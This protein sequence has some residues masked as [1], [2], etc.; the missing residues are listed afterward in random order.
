MKTHI[1]NLNVCMG[2]YFS[3][4]IIAYSIVDIV[5]RLSLLTVTYIYI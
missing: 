4:N 2:C 3:F 5:V 1:Y